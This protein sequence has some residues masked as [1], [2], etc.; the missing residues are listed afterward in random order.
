MKGDEKGI[1]TKS[2]GMR[3]NT[4]GKGEQTMADERNTI[5]DALLKLELAA[6]DALVAFDSRYGEPAVLGEDEIRAAVRLAFINKL[7]EL[8]GCKPAEIYDHLLACIL[9]EL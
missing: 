2:S 5:N 3:M 4:E 8:E 9:Q 7:A 1:I 6:R